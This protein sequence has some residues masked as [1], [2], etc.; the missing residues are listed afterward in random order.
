M[1]EATLTAPDEATT[2]AA[3]PDQDQQDDD[4]TAFLDGRST[5]DAGTEQGTTD[6]TDTTVDDVEEQARQAE[7][8]AE[9]ARQAEAL[10]QEERQREAEERERL[11]NERRVEGVNQAY[12]TRAAAIAKA[13]DDEGVSATVKEAILTQFNE[14]HAQG[15]LFHSTNFTTG[16]YKTLANLLPE[17]KREDFMALRPKHKSFADVV[18]SYEEMKTPLLR[19]GYVSK[20]DHEAEV[21]KAV[22]AFARDLDANGGEKLRARLSRVSGSPAVVQGERD[23]RDDRAKLA[24]PTTPI[25]EIRAI[26]A[27][28]RAG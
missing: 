4:V 18:G 2:P 21:A 9:A 27:R 28:Q 23:S 25:E 8:K 12:R 22:R 1:A 11:E 16:L 19:D 3:I 26:R 7:I 17:D 10:R 15:Q 6:R 24:D 5:P 20:A 13:L 14:H